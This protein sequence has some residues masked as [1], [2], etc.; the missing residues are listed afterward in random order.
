EA[1]I[2]SEHAGTTRDVIEVYMDLGGLPVTFLDTAG[3]RES[4][5]EV[6]EIGVKRGMTRAINAD[7]RLILDDGTGAALP[8]EVGPEDML[9]MTK[10]DLG[11]GGEISAK[12][13]Q[14]LE[15]L[16]SQVTEKLGLLASGA[17]LAVRARHRKQMQRAIEALEIASTRLNEMP[18]RAEIVAE[19]LRTSIHALD[20]LVGR[21]DV[22]DV[23][24]DIFAHFCIG[25]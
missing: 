22:E 11:N 8:F 19:E 1:A 24:G 3:V 10:S 21:V 6:E 5:D 25:K 23:L 18:D 13:G 7:L 4:E 16:V 17:G 9:I 2:T 15:S 12:T 20:A 14:G